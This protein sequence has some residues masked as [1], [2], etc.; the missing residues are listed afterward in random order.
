MLITALSLLTPLLTLM[1]GDGPQLPFVEK[2]E[3]GAAERWQTFGGQWDFEPGVLRQSAKDFDCGAVLKTKPEGPFYLAVRFKP[4]SSFV[5]GGLMFA[6]PQPDKKDGGVLVR[7]DPEGRVLWG[8]FDESGEFQFQGD[9]PI[10][11]DVGTAEQELAIAVDPEKRAFNIFHNGKRIATN[12]KTYRGAGF[13]GLQSSGGPH[14]FVRFEA[15]AA[16]AAELEGLEIPGRFARI[17]DILGCETRVVALHEEHKFL[18]RHGPDGKE[19]DRVTLAQLEGLEGGE[20]YPVGLSFDMLESWEGLANIL[21]LAERGRA[22][23]LFTPN[24]TQFG[25]GPLV[26]QPKM[27]GTGLAVGP[28]G[29]IFVADAAIPGIRVFD[30]GGKELLTF[31]QKGK[32]D[33]YAAPSPAAFGKFDQP[34]GIAVDAEGRI[35]V[36]DKGNCTYVA[37]RYDGVENK[38]EW[39]THGPWVPNPGRVR[40]DKKGNL[41]LAGPHEYYAPYGALRVMTLDGKPLGAFVGAAVGNM[42]TSLTICYGPDNRYFIADA[43]KDRVLFVNPEFVEP[44]PAFA[45]TE[46]GAI[47]LTM[48]RTDGK[49]RKSVS[50]EE[51]QAGDRLLAK[52]IEAICYGWP[53][54]KPETLPRY[55]LP[56]APPAGQ[57]HVIDMPVLVA[58]FTQGRDEKGQVITIDPSG[59]IERL[60]RELATARTFYWL[61]SRCTLNIVFDYMLVEGVEAQV[62]GG[63]VQPVEA[64]RLV[65]EAR[66]KNGLPPISGDHSLIGIHPMAGFDPNDTDD[67]GYV[68]GGGLTPYAYSGYA[69]WNHGQAWL[70]GHEWGHQLDAYFDKSGFTDWWLNH[71]D[72]T[73]HTG[74][75]G[76]HWDCNAFLCRRA[77]K[78]NWLRLRFGTLRTVA[79]VDGDG[80]PDEDAALPLDE[81]RFG[82]DPTKKDTD[83]DGLDDLGELIAGTFT[84]ADPRNPDTNANGVPDGQDPYPQFA[85][86]TVVT[87]SPAGDATGATFARLGAVQRTWCD[88]E[89][90]ATYDAD[91]L[92]LRFALRKPAKHVFA[93]V[94][95]NNDGWFVGRDNVPAHVELEWPKDA[96]PTIKAKEH[97]EA[98]IVLTDSGPLLE[99]SVARPEARA[100]LRAGSK[101]GV[102]VRFQNGGGT[103]AFL[104]DP[105]QILGLELK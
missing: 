23:Y 46:D 84:S 22:I 89:V 80:V 24:L 90:S 38:F 31:G 55:A 76:E 98:T 92:R 83:G 69:L 39:V 37:Y 14:A 36:S 25:H 21:M 60:K 59:V 18:V 19:T 97:G 66:Q 61:N 16:K 2:F 65:N 7:C 5:G 78:M 72:G 48:T 28:G 100:P 88:A 15:R 99:V 6:L 67:V 52:Q 26:R 105:W 94:D 13:I 58:V 102:T 71:P 82:S 68:G 35:V 40:F 95:F 4:Q 86:G 91:H 30:I 77:D 85:V 74:R 53:P 10:L 79:D 63:W 81:K 1:S 56:K 57:T 3:Q 73:V 70:F 45:W 75:Y 93:T 41:L 51:N 8:C 87:G 11:E 54:I 104:L 27:R 12:V 17:I 33:A 32:I 9:K 50:R 43:E 20:L 44:L 42:S 96:P 34:S 29:H 49:I 101:V 62:E 64:R 47:E 103:I